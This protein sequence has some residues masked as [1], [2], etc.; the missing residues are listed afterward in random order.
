MRDNV[1][2]LPFGERPGVIFAA[3]I[4]AALVVSYVEFDGE[5]HVTAAVFGVVFAALY[6]KANR[7]LIS[8]E[9]LHRHVAPEV[10]A[11]D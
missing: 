8:L 10:F 11:E 9:I 2:R 6:N 4:A 1:P 3:W 7:I 5:Y